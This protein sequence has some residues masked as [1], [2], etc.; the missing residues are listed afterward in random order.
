MQETFDL[1]AYAGQTAFFRF[2]YITDWASNEAGFYVDDVVIADASG[3][4]FS[5]GLE[6]GSGN[7]VLDGWTRTTGLA[8]NDW[9]LTFIN[10]IYTGGKFAGYAIQDDSIYPDGDY[11]VDHTILNTQNLN[12][13][14]VTIILSNHL[15]EET[16]FPASY[17]LLVEKGDASK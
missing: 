8:V 9:A 6:V 2:L 4:P 11:Q 17:Q 12:R 16:S 15:P 7:W 14:Q 10:P 1:S 13:D 5:D 3:T